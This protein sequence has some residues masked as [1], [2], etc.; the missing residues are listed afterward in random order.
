VLVVLGVLLVTVAVTG[1]VSAS[2]TWPLW[3]VLRRVR[4]TTPER[5]AVAARDG[6][7]DGRVVAVAGMAT[8][9][10]SG[11]LH[12]VVNDEPCVWHRH[13]VHRRQI[14]YR[15]TPRGT[16]QRYSLRRRVA[17]VASTQPFLLLGVPT[18]PLQS[19]APSPAVVE[20]APAGMRMHGPVP[21]RLRILPG[22]ASEPFPAA[23]KIIGRVGQLYW[24]REWVLRP[25][26]RIFVLGQ[27][28]SDGHRLSLRRP[29]QG[30]HVVSTRTAV[31]LRRSTGMSAVGGVLLA[32]LGGLAGATLLIVHFV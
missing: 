17:D 5:L 23:D 16:V 28:R 2:R 26:T 15:T 19:G 3:T 21:G 10:A 7:L 13:V 14:R 6:H 8:A 1:A 12:S 30:P 31:W 20:V 25:G 27:V 9:A 18:Q 29:S 32:T 22:L 4:P 11:A 24:H